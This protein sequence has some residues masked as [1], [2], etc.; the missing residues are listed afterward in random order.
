[1]EARRPPEG[2]SLAP[3]QKNFRFCSVSPVYKCDLFEC[4]ASVRPCLKKRIIIATLWLT[5]TLVWL[6]FIFIWT[7]ISH[8]EGSTGGY[9]SL[10]SL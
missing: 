6:V 5:M 7:G 2:L 3:S 8:V 10:D 4:I 9:A 1:M